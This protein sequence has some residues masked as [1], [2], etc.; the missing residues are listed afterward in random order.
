[1]P[2]NSLDGLCLTENIY[3]TYQLI[4]FGAFNKGSYSPV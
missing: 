1:M 4:S 3:E 2:L